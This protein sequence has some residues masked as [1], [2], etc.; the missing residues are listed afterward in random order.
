MGTGMEVFTVSHV[1]RVVPSDHSHQPIW[2]RTHLVITTWYQVD[3]TR[4]YRVVLN[5]K[6]TESTE[7]KM[8]TARI[9]PTALV[10]HIYNNYPTAPS[11]C[12]MFCI[13]HHYVLVQIAILNIFVMY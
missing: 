12:Y 5:S 4:W 8:H 11:V 6:L 2:H 9:E 10:E 3:F 13:Y 1:Y 7:K